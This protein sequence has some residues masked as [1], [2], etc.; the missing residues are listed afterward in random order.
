MTT[1]YATVTVWVLVDG[2]GNHVAHDDEAALVDAY[3]ERIQPLADAGGV[4]RVKLTV[5]VPLPVT[6]ELSGE[7]TA[8]ETQTGLSAV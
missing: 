5:K 8:D 3:E 2:D 4:R 6:I 7:V 1:T